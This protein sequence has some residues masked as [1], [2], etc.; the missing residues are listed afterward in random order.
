MSF[1][2]SVGFS[3]EGSGLEKVFE[4]VYGKNSVTYTFSGKPFPGHFVVISLS[5]QLFG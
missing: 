3:M 2:G 1:V 5:I 4:T